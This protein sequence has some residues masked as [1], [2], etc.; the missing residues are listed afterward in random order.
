MIVN[1]L[2]IPKIQFWESIDNCTF[3]EIML[4]CLKKVKNSIIPNRYEKNNTCIRFFVSKLGLEDNKITMS[5]KSIFKKNEQIHFI[6][7]K[8]FWRQK[9]KSSYKNS[10]LFLNFLRFLVSVFP[11]QFNAN[12]HF[13][14]C[15]LEKI[16][17]GE[18]FRQKVWSG[19]FSNGQLT[20]EIEFSEFS[21]NWPSIYPFER[22][23]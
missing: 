13:S 9:K 3:P 5:K 11:R 21:K 12:I 19:G 4:F 6:I 18:S 7:N 17:F 23:D 20:L 10:F 15:W 2:E 22:I 1:F 8:P 14:I 16:L